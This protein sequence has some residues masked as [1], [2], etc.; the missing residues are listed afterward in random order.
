MPES[1]EPESPPNPYRSPSVVRRQPGIHGEQARRQAS[2]FLY[3]EIELSG[4]FDGV[5]RYNGWWFVQRIH[6]DDKL[7]W[8]KISWLRVERLIEFMLPTAAGGS[9]MATIQIDFGARL[10]FRRF[11]LLADDQSVYDETC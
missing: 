10:Q 1:D 11:Q 4:R 9:V 3:R 5:L 7:L 6:L 8:R 2:G